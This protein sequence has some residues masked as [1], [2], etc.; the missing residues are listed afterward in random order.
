ML[1]DSVRLPAVQECLVGGS[2]LGEAEVALT[3]QRFESA[4]QHGL[5]VL[6]TTLCQEGV[7]SSERLVADAAVRN[8]I[9]IVAGIAIERRQRALKEGRSDG[10]AHVDAGVE[11]LSSDAHASAGHPI[12]AGAKPVQ[13]LVDG[14]GFSPRKLTH[15][16]GVAVRPRNR[17]RNSEACGPALVRRVIDVPAFALDQFVDQLVNICRILHSPLLLESSAS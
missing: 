9:E 8:Q 16:P 12:E 6:K 10:G 15:G 14:H 3:L 4:H 2:P 13:A 5:A 7:E 11:Q 1:T 17:L